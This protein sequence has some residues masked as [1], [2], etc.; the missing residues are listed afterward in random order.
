MAID[1]TKLGI[2][3][4]VYKAD[5][6]DIT[7]NGEDVLVEDSDAAALT[8]TI[9]AN[10]AKGTERKQGNK[11]NALIFKH[12]GTSVATSVNTDDGNLNNFE[13]W[14]LGSASAD[15]TW[16]NVN[17]IVEEEGITLDPEGTPSGI[18]YSARSV[19]AA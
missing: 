13:I 5:A 19:V 17:L 11:V 14:Q 15:V 12:V 2:E 9:K 18:K 6:G 3:K 4:F 1:V 10:T 7:F 16:A 8:T